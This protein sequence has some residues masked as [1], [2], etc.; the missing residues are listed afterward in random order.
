LGPRGFDVT[1]AVAD[2]GRSVL[3]KAELEDQAVGR[4][5]PDAHEPDVQA[6]LVVKGAKADAISGLI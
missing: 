6:A 3:A 1:G 2:E 5:A 4:A